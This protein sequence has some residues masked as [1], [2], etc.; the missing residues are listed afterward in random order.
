MIYLRIIIAAAIL[1]T[2]GI[3]LRN[4]WLA[5]CNYNRY[6]KYVLP[7]GSVAGD[8]DAAGR[9]AI[10]GGCSCSQLRRS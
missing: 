8:G 10:A 6:R 9:A 7:R 4:L 3:G 1:T 2:L 5:V